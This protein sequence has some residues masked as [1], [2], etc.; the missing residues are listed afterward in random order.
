MDGYDDPGSWNAWIETATDEPVRSYLRE[1]GEIHRLTEAEAVALLPGVVGGD[2]ESKVRFTEAYLQLVVYIA[3]DFTGVG[4]ELLDLIGAGNIGLI[5]AIEKIGE[6]PPG[7]TFVE[8]A[9]NL[10]RQAMSD[11]LTKE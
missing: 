3:R 8:F 1:I 5:R 11:R 2:F 10:I 7:M 4:V 6:V 9:A